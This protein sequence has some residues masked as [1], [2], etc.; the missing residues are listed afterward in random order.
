[1]FEAHTNL[2]RASDG[3]LIFL[4]G[5][6]GFGFGLLG[7]TLSAV[8]NQGTGIRV[9][10]SGLGLRWGTVSLNNNSEA[11]LVVQLASKVVAQG[12]TPILLTITGN[13]NGCVMVDDSSVFLDGPIIENNGVADVALTFGAHA[14]LLGNRI[15][16][17]ICEPTVLIRGQ[18][19][20]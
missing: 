8:G 16:H 14:T 9:I 15:G 4:L 2:I 6:V 7:G 10:S 11:G 19:C 20:S 13:S 12:V 18:P 17:I 1:M 3:I 5:E